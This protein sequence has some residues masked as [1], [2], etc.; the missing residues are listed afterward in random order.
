MEVKIHVDAHATLRFN[1]ARNVPHAIREQVKEALCKLVDAGIV[2]PVRH[3]EWAAPIVPILKADGSIRVC[4]DYKI[5]VNQ[6]AK[7]DSY[8]LP[9]VN[10]LLAR[11]GRAK[12]FSKL[13]MSQAYQQLALDEQSKPFVTT[14]TH[15]GLFQYNRL[16][17]GVSAAPAIFQRTMENLLQDMGVSIS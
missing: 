5:A 8:S 12:I 6:V 2:E 17:F 1:R 11:L 13:D 15:K 14:N 16:P 9:W 4:G 10:D 7:P 3:S